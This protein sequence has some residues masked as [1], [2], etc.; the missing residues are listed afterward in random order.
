MNVKPILLRTNATDTFRPDTIGD[1][2][3]LVVDFSE[4][5]RQSMLLQHKVYRL[6]DQT[7]LT[8]EIQDLLNIT[9][10][11]YAVDQT[12][13]REIN[14]YLN[15]SR[16]FR[17]Y[18][19]VKILP[20][21]EAI[22]E[23]LQK[24]LSFLS[25]DKWEFVFR[26]GT[27]DTAKLISKKYAFPNT[28]TKVCLF[29]G[30]LDSFIGAI[31]LLHRGDHLALVGHHKKGGGEGQTQEE[32]FQLLKSTYPNQNVVNFPFY[33]QP[34]QAFEGAQKEVS[35]RARSILFIGL[36]LAV[37]NCCNNIPLIIPENGFISLN[38]PLTFTRHGSHSTRTTHPY[39]LYSF[40]QILNKLSIPIQIDNP[41]QFKTKGEMVGDCE[42][43]ALL[44]AHFKSTLSCAHP[45][46]ARFK[47]LPPGTHCGY[48]TPCLIRRASLEVN[49]LRDTKYVM[50]VQTD[51]IHVHKGSGRDPRAFRLALERFRV[52]NPRHT[53][54]HIMNSGP[55]SHFSQQEL[56][57]LTNMYRKG[58]QEIEQIL[59]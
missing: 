6:I 25:G 27:P 32:L 26:E 21:W 35:S 59:P 19:P 16:H 38:V 40:Q 34:N 24:M 55:L 2:E 50:N 23:E 54:I 33:V 42:N 3:L 57:D 45:D 12:V 22:Q 53:L 47:K 10:M 56:I 5:D 41:Y 44:K 20:K 18:V 36:G 31:D 28:L 51:P 52:M 15:W 39:F 9:L 11:A 17:C 1:A 14:G 30:G 48:C 4:Q 8:E 29:S 7:K 49:G 58:M 13:S 46:Q 43:P 37:A